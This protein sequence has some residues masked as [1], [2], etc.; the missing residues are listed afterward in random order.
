MSPSLI[1]RCRIW[2]GF[3]WPA[4]YARMTPAASIPDHNPVGPDIRTN[5]GIL[6][7]DQTVNGYLIQNRYAKRSSLIK[8]R[9]PGR[10][11]GTNAANSKDTP[12]RTAEPDRLVSNLHSPGQH[13]CWRKTMQSTRLVAVEHLEEL[14]LPGHGCRQRAGRRSRP[15]QRDTLR[16]GLY[17]LPDAGD[18]R[19]RGHQKPSGRT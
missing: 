9:S 16:S 17:G 3:T 18:G 12:R 6:I 7:A 4:G 8:E 13:P 2:M 15:L 10:E 14:G 11:R 19:V 5:E 1:W